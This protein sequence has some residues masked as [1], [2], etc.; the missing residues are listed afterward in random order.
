MARS[1]ILMLVA[2]SV[3]VE[4]PVEDAL[5][6]QAEP[7]VRAGTVEPAEGYDKRLDAYGITIEATDQVRNDWLYYAALVYEHMT[8]HPISH[9]V[10]QSILLPL[11]L[12]LLQLLLLLPLLLL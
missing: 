5:A 7:E 8:D 6:R 9:S 1:R 2:I 11:L 12:L 10:R 3:V 4:L